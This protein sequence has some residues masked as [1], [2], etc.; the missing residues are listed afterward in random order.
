M[1]VRWFIHSSRKNHQKSYS[2]RY[3]TSKRLISHDI[4]SN[5]YNYKYTTMV[6][7]VPICK[8]RRVRWRFCLYVAQTFQDDIVCLSKKQSKQLGNI[9]PV[10]ICSRVTQN[11]YLI[12]PKT[13]KSMCWFTSMEITGMCFQ[14][15]QLPLVIIG[16]HLLLLCAIQNTWLNTLF[17][18]LIFWIQI[19]NLTFTE[20]SL[21]K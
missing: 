17:V 6:E 11:I 10:C 12:D 4:H 15:R 9:G 14:L 16:D 7:I 20:K 5:I 13:L 1:P 19:L 21:K 8:V 18:K 2:Y 3:E